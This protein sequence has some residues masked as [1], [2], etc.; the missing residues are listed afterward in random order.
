MPPGRTL[1]WWLG[2]GWNLIP[3]EGRAVHRFTITAN[4][5]SACCPSSRT[6]WIWLSSVTKRQADMGA[7]LG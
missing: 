3:K 6:T 4:G 7:W 1:R 2:Q 5:H